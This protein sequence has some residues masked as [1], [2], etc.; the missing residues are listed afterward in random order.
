LLQKAVEDDSYTF[1]TFCGGDR[2]VSLIC[3]NGKIVIPPV[4][5]KRITE[6]YHLQLGHP[7]ET[8]TEQTIKQHFWWNKLRES[9]HDVCKK[10]HTCQVAKKSQIKYGHLPPK[11]AE[12]VPWETLCVDLIGPY[13]IRQNK[14]NK[15]K[16]LTLWCVTMI[17]PATG[18]IE[19]K[20]IPTKTAD[21]VAN[22]VEQ[23][24]L[25]RY[26]KPDKLIHDQGGEFKAEF[27]E[28]ICK[29]Y[30]IKRHPISTRNPQANAILE[31]VHQTIGNILRTYIYHQADLEEDDPWSGILAATMF[32]IRATYHTT[33]QATPMQ[34]VFGRDAFLNTMFEANWQYIKERKQKLIKLNNEWENA[35]RK[36][37]TYHVNDKILLQNRM[38]TKF[39]ETAYTGPYQIVRVNDN[40]TVQICKGAV[41]ET[42][43]IRLIKPYAE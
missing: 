17:D 29:D 27:A 33:L 7:G 20:E 34:L 25:T 12:Y 41:I 6:W 8:R 15:K 26:P 38:D 39:G 14:N 23:T 4:L 37:Y 1:T 13:Q 9:V 18:W 42:V 31:R 3:Y 2:K 35:K 43:N 10:C 36:P 40:G 11:E 21:V 24:W 28:M 16:T 19:I 32:A 22:L 5:Q 30:G